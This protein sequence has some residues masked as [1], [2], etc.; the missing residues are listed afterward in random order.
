MAITLDTLILDVLDE[1]PRSIDIF[2]KYG[3]GQIEDPG[4]RELAAGAS[5][6]V[7]VDFV[8]LPREEAAALVDEL[9]AVAA[10]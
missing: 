3:M 7:A 6:K 4:V 1:H 5:L 10:G 2:R 9:N 8:G